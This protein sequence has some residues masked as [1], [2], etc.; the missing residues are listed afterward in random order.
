MLEQ[1]LGYLKNWFRVRDDVDGIHSGT[2]EV[3][4]GKIVLPFIRNGQY[5]RVCNSV[6]NDGLYKMSDDGDL[7]DGDGK[8]CTLRDE[9]FSGSVWALKIPK[10]VVD[11]SAEI[12]TWAEQNGAVLNSPYSSESFGG[13]SY[14]KAV[15]VGSSS[16]DFVG[17]L[18]PEF[19]NRLN[20]HKRI[21]E[22]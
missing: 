9:T 21:R 19:A 17:N 5:F 14:S 8:P 18:P 3:K 12:A 10:S 1:L 4:G 2:Y 22:I 7:L 20:Q 6:L 13:Y 15:G 11:L 16:N